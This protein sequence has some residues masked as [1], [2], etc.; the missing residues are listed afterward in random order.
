MTRRERSESDSYVFE[1]LVAQ[2]TNPFFPAADLRESFARGAV[3]MEE[4]VPAL[5]FVQAFFGG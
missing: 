4:Q 1:A 2:D 3:K 5:R